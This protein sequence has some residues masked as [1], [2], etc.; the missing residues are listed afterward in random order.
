MDD[1]SIDLKKLC[2]FLI[3]LYPRN[4]IPN[5]LAEELEA[6]STTQSLFNILTNHGLWTFMNYHLLKIFMDEYMP[7][8]DEQQKQMKCYIA[9]VE[10]FAS[11][12]SIHEYI[13]I[14]QVPTT[15]PK[16]KEESLVPAGAHS[17]DPELFSCLTT[18]V[19][20]S[21]QQEKLSHVL[22]LW[23]Y[24]MKHFSLSHPTLLLGSITSGSVVIKWHFPQ[25]ETKRIS[26]TA[27]SSSDFYK[28]HNIVQ[29]TING[30]LVYG[31]TVTATAHGRQEVG[32]Y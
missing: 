23:D 16:S 24:L 1:V 30:Q 12:T 18:K 21:A 10:Q 28:E 2:H 6:A 9:D 5:P 25:V 14:C 17:P 19:E 7:H 27:V 3:S 4:S 29:V 31:H 15:A 26:S 13:A 8:D 11:A 20:L 22:A 32:R